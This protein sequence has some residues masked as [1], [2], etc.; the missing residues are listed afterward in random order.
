MENF[1]ATVEKF[2]KLT[3]KRQLQVVQLATN[4]ML[5]GIEVRAGINRGGARYTGVIPRD[6]GSLAASLQTDL[7]GHRVGGGEDSF[8]FTIEQMESGDEI[9]F[10]WGGGAAPYVEEVYYGANGVPGTFW[11]DHA[12]QSWQS[13]VSD[14][15]ALAETL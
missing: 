5:V 14:A 11:I 12:A 10:S 13:Y 15:V 7:N 8:S 6:L 3:K 2:V 9:T 4:D 1:E